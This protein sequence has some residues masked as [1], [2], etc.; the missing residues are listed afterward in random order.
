LL[1]TLSDRPEIE[2]LERYLDTLLE[3]RGEELEFVV[4]FGS[5]AKG[6][7]SRGSDY[8]LLIGLRGEDGKRLIDRMAD[9]DLP[10]QIDIQV[11]PYNRSAWQRMFETYHL[12]FLEAL[13]HGV[14]LW[15]RGGFAE[16]REVFRQWRESGRVTPWRS[17][18]RIAA[19]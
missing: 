12:L 18:W 19:S 8:D 14:V 16:M 3:Q 7:W 6:N 1:K 9:F 11:F 13:E 10:A 2:K 17:G 4:L 5:M 15:D